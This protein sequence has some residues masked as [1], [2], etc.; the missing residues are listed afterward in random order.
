MP[1][2][3]DKDNDEP[4]NRLRFM[5][6]EDDDVHHIA[7][8]ELNLWMETLHSYFTLFFTPKGY[9]G[10][11][12]KG[13]MP[14]DPVCIIPGCDVPLVFRKTLPPSDEV[15]MAQQPR[16]SKFRSEDSVTTDNIAPSSKSE[17]IEQGPPSHQNLDLTGHLLVGECCKSRATN[18]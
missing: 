10:L 5:G 9:L 15:E 18:P 11:G 14:G 2:M 16:F 4:P 17:A 7:G 1:I 8:Q 3:W 12:L 6:A 13:V